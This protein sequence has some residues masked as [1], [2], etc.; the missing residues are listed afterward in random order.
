[1]NRQA[2]LDNYTRDQES[3]PPENSCDHLGD[4]V[5]HEESFGCCSGGVFEP[6]HHCRLL[7]K[8][9]QLEK[10]LNIDSCLDCKDDT[11][12]AGVPRRRKLNGR[13][14]KWSYGVTT[15][16]QRLDDGTLERTLKSLALAGFDCP[17]LFL[18]GI[19]DVSPFEKFGL[20]MTSRYPNVRR[21]GNWV[22]SMW[23]LYLRE[24]TATHY[25]IFQ[26]DFVTY[27][28]LILSDILV[29][30]VVCGTGS[31]LRPRRFVARVSML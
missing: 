5:R 13:L 11:R 27:K 6:V 30:S 17:R 31:I 1:M 25:A 2:A 19:K 26:D 28:G 8:E 20:E 23:E 22:L 15:V 16:K 7:G 12:K 3:R 10:N 29:R 21:F 4:V 24:P 14:I 9:C 18:D